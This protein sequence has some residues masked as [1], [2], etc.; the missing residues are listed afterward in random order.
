MKINLK[1]GIGGIICILIGYFITDSIFSSQVPPPNLR[2]IEELELYVNG[3]FWACKNL[4]NSVSN[5]GNV[6]IGFVNE[7]IVY[8]TG[9]D[10]NPLFNNLSYSVVSPFHV[11]IYR[12]HIPIWNVFFDEKTDTCF[13]VNLKDG[14]AIYHGNLIE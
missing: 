14:E 8:D 12:K 3:T 2:T 13:V 11:K 6:T 5:N 7:N 1:L 10:N 4:P 9:D